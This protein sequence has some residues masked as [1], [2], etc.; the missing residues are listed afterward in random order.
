MPQKVNPINFENSEGNICIANSIIEGIT[1]KLPVSRL[2]RDLTDSTI[3]RNIGVPFAHTMIALNSLEKGINK[4]MI[5]EQKILLDLENNW[6]I[7]AEALQTILRRE[8][9]PNPYEEL[10]KLTRKNSVINAKSISEFI[11]QLEIKEN[12]K[13][14]LQKITPQNYLGVK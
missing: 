6:A 12:I 1:R 11:N 13:E 9:Y 3:L 7:V 8:G 5:N 14:E 2:Q 10:K 4:L